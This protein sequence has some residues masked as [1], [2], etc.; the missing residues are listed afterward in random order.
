[1]TNNNKVTKATKDLESLRTQVNDV[2][3][4][5]VKERKRLDEAKEAGNSK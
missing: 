2:E 4:T 3:K 5:I 1:M